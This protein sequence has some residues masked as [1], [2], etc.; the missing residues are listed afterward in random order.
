[1]PS[2]PPETPIVAAKW[3]E[4][5][6]PVDIAIGLLVLLAAFLTASFAARNTDLYR[7]LASGRLIAN[8]EYPIG[9][10]PLSFTG[11]ERPWVNTNWL[12]ELGIY[13]LYS[14][15]RTG[16]VLVAAKAIFFAAAMGLIFCL[17]RGEQSLWAW[18]LL[19]GVGVIAL[20]SQT[21]LRPQVWGMFC[22]SLL[23][24]GLY[25]LNWKQSRW[26]APGMIAGIILVWTNTDSFAI[27][28]VLTILLLI[29]GDAITRNLLPDIADQDDDAFFHAP[30]RDALM[31]I[32]LL[33]SI[34]FFLNPTFIAGLTKNPVEAMSQ[35][36]PFEF[37]VTP[38]T[39]DSDRQLSIYSMSPLDESFMMQ[40]ERGYNIGGAALVVLLI[41]GA[42]TM[43][44]DYQR[45][46][47]TRIV[48][49]FGFILL[50]VKHYRF[51][52]FLV[53][54]VIPICA[55]HINAMF[56]RIKLGVITEQRTRSILTACGVGRI[57]TVFAAIGL[58]A[59]AIPGWLHPS[60][61]NVAYARRV[62]FYIDA[63]AGMS[64]AATRLEEW[65]REKQLP[66]DVHGMLHNVDFGDYCA[67]FAPSEKT[68][69]N[70]RFRFHREE[71]ID[72]LQLR[73]EYAQRTPPKENEPA[74]TT[75]VAIDD[76]FKK[77]QASYIC[78]GNSYS[79]LPY[80]VL[81]WMISDVAIADTQT[82]PFWYVNG[83]VAILGRTSTEA[84]RALSR[85]LRYSVA[86]QTFGPQ[87]NL[88]PS[89]QATMPAPAVDGWLMDYLQRPTPGS[90]D[91]DESIFLSI[92]S[93]IYQEQ[94]DIL[95]R[96]R[97]IEISLQVGAI[98]GSAIAG[99]ITIPNRQMTG[100][101]FAL[102]IAA[103]RAARRGIAEN[104]DHPEAYNALA[105]AYSMPLM[106]EGEAGDVAA[107]ELTAIWR[108]LAR[109]PSGEQV[110]DKNRTA[111]QLAPDVI[112]QC[113]RAAYIYLRHPAIPQPSMSGM[114][115]AAKVLKIA[116]SYLPLC[117]DNT[118]PPP[119][120]YATLRLR[121][122]QYTANPN[123]PPPSNDPDLTE[124]QKGKFDA[125]MYR[126]MLKR[127]FQETENVTKSMIDRIGKQLDR[128][129]LAG[130]F[131]N[132]AA[133]GLPMHAM[134]MIESA[135]KKKGDSPF[136]FQELGMNP[137]DFFIDLTRLQLAA[138]FLEE[139]AGAITSLKDEIGKYQDK[140]P[141]DPA[142]PILQLKI[143]LLELFKCK[144]EG[145]YKEAR[146]IH[147]EVVGKRLDTVSVADVAPFL[148]PIISQPFAA[149]AVMGPMI[150]ITTSEGQERAASKIVP[151][152]RYYFQAGVIALLE[153]DNP[154]ARSYFEK[155]H[156]IQGVDLRLLGLEQA[157]RGR[158]YAALL[159][160]YASQPIVK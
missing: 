101:D 15:D 49:W 145:N 82:I 31:R 7:H 96:N 127:L 34:A 79:R 86:Q 149:S 136:T 59:A 84:D 97:A 33:S 152:S 56:G 112:H 63:D 45:L 13:A 158:I 52:P 151:V 103:A 61:G 109:C 91:A 4:W 5:F 98:A 35:L 67:W 40:P 14:L 159:K 147:D 17:R 38:K 137:F 89:I 62:A 20:A 156:T 8:G 100:E 12:F 80:D 55:A 25:R 68:F 21:S 28:G 85:K 46:N 140:R 75:T 121:F 66:D 122:L 83:R 87:Q 108:F 43:A 2:L 113:M 27:L 128:F 154:A 131:T 32:L 30:N 119:G 72:L 123:L 10:D 117:N 106:P 39:L 26:R 144:L 135:R 70:S 77:Y 48:L 143:K 36:I 81:I 78:L 88:V 126:E 115:L 1:V 58:V 74:K 146:L 141:D 53:I 3:P 125:K 92:Y 94:M 6:R 54:V 99:K 22:F 76:L 64:R 71:L 37:S 148:K 16:A 24:V 60:F 157:N 102:P 107:Q 118:L 138:G 124:Y 142:L 41:L 134:N 114:D 29:I 133:V 111:V 130:Q 132:Y 150:L 50:S 65:R 11:A 105:K 104:P 9:S 90:D 95:W 18:V 51:L 155:C 116:S 153:G 120:F 93:Q 139:A 19:V 129:P 69:M 23:L 73:A 47:A 110:N 57:L 42:A 44:W 160:E